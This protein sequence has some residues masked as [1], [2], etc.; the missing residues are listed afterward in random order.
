MITKDSIT[1]KQ[2][3]KL[4]KLLERWVRADVM[5]RLGRFDNLEYLDYVQLKIEYEDK[6]R[7]MLF[8]TSNLAEL[9]RLWGIRKRG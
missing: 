3:H 7:T 8:D 5:S 6:I 1:R 2:A 9:A 4:V